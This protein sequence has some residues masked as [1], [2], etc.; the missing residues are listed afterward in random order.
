MIP[1]PYIFELRECQ[2]KL[3]ERKTGR[4]SGMSRKNETSSVDFF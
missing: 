4:D 2:L 3:V 1:Y